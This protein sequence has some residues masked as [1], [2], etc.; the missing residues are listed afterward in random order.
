MKTMIADRG[1]G[2]PISLAAALAAGKK[3]P[4]DVTNLLADDHEIVLGWFDWY[5]QA[6]DPQVR[7][8]VARKICTA[9]R[10]HM[11]AEEEIFYPEAARAS[12]DDELVQ[13]SIQEH[14]AAQG[15]MDRLE[16]ARTIDA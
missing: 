1:M 8:R 16:A 10:A 4:P 6:D 13:R 15:L 2:E 12:G 3:V 7:E 11:A 9:L 14:R 5:E